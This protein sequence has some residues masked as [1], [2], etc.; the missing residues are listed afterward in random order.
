MG[1]DA[2]GNQNRGMQLVSPAE[3]SAIVEMYRHQLAQQMRQL[4]GITS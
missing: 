3:V 4:Y 1:P 2:S